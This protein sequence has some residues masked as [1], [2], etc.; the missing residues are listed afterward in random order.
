MSQIELQTAVEASLPHPSLTIRARS[1]HPHE[2]ASPK[3]GDAGPGDIELVELGRNTS[4]DTPSVATIPAPSD[5][6]PAPSAKARRKA[7]IQFLALCWT[8]FTL[9]WNDGTTGPLLPRIQSVYNVGMTRHRSCKSTEP[10][11]RSDTPSSPSSSYSRVL[12]VLFNY[13]S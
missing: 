8:L 3:R 11:D 2:P 10:V 13:V 9:G 5:P 7:R 12:Y 4:K 6:P 1:P